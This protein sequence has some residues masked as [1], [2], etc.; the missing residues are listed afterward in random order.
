[1]G[2]IGGSRLKL[3]SQTNRQNSCLSAGRDV[4]SHLF[5]INMVCTDSFIS[6]KLMMDSLTVTSTFS[7][8]V[9]SL[10]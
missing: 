7:F 9:N 10:F 1:M 2:L 5:S 6:A 8:S 4:V 3:P